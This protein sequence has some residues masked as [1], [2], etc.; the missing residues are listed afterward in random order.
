MVE[1]NKTEEKVNYRQKIMKK[2]NKSKMFK[3]SIH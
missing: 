1:I 2:K 3:I